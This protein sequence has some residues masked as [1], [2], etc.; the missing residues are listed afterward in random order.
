MKTYYW[1]LTKRDGSQAEGKFSLA[2][3]V[4]GRVFLGEKYRIIG[5]WI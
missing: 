5:G 4:F 1:H 3:R 2:R